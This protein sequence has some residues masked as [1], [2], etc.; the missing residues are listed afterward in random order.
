M[1]LTNTLQQWLTEQKWDL[2]PEIDAKNKTSSIAFTCTIDDFKLSCDFEIDEKSGLVKFYMHFLEKEIPD[3]LFDKVQ[4][5]CTEETN[6][7]L[8]GGVWALKKRKIIFYTSAIDVNNAAF[9]T[10][11]INNLMNAGVNFMRHFLPKFVEI[12]E[13]KAPSASSKTTNLKHMKTDPPMNDEVEN[14]E[15]EN[16]EDEDEDEDEE[17]EES[18]PPPPVIPMTQ[19]D[20]NE[21]GSLIAKK[22]KPLTYALMTWVKKYKKMED[23]I[24]IADDEDSAEWETKYTR[25]DGPDFEVYFNTYEKPG[26]ISLFIYCPETEIE[27]NQI[28]DARRLV[29]ERNIKLGTG[30]FQLIRDDAAFRY[31]IGINVSG[32]ASKDPDY[33]GEHLIS[34]KLI[35]NMF[36]DGISAMEKF[37][38]YWLDVYCDEE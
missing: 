25:E 22:V 37:I 33:Q 3:S 19:F 14:D 7:A 24:D 34:P 20:Q 13:S 18:T 2:K 23:T 6:R 36:D 32:I 28:S 38:D 10:N 1:R 8:L 31:Y 9:D 15:V 16:D 35:D 21:D 27:E 26:I 4:L 11:H 29:L 30:Q 12:C 5:M 17:N